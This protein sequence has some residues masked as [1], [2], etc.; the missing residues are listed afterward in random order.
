MPTQ[1]TLSAADGQAPFQLELAMK[2]IAPTYVEPLVGGALRVELAGGEQEISGQDQRPA[3][4]ANDSIQMS[5]VMPA[6]FLST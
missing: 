4:P 1:M 6:R 3:N 2:P 5:S